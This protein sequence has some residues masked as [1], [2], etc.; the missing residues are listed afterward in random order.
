MVRCGPTIL[1]AN[2]RT[3]G[4]ILKLPRG[5]YGTNSSTLDKSGARGH[6]AVRTDHPF[7]K[8]LHLLFKSK[9]DEFVPQTQ[10]GILKIVPQMIRTHHPFR[11]ES[12]LRHY[13][14]LQAP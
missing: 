14:G 7:R 1:S 6:Y 3:C 8:P 12:H 10:H 5:V 9:V 2:R 11:E 13:G 4:I